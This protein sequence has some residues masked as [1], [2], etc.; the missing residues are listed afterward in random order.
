MPGIATSL[1]EAPR[2]DVILASAKSKKS[3]YI[4]GSDN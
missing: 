4:S 2:N 3:A 1:V